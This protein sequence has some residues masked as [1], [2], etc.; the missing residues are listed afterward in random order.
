MTN[1]EK[2]K[3]YNIKLFPTY[4]MVA[5]DFIFFYAIEYVFLTSVKNFSSAQVVLLDSLIPLFC[6][7]VNIPC[8][9][10]VEK[11][12]K[13]VGMAVSNFA[14]M[15]CLILLILG[16]NIYY[17][18]FGFFFNAIGFCLKRL[19]DTNFLA[20][21]IEMKS[22]EGRKLFSTVIAISNRNYYVLD[23]VTS[24]L[25]GLT[26]M[27]NG[28]LP[29]I[30]SLAFATMAFVISLMFKNVET[31][32]EKEEEE[33][34]KVGKAFKREFKNVIDSFKT[35]LKS[36]R[37]RSFL[38]F[39]LAFNGILYGSYMLRST[40]LSE[41]YEI[42]D[43]SLAFL[44]AGMT[45]VSGLTAIVQEKLKDK[46]RNKNLAFISLVFIGTYILTS[47]VAGSTMPF[48]FKL[49][50]TIFFFML[51]Y[52]INSANEIAASSYSKNFTTSKIRVKISAAYAI[53]KN[54]SEFITTFA[55]GL[56]LEGIAIEKLFMYI[57]LV[58]AVIL[59]LVLLYM[60]KHFG[61]KPEEYDKSEI[62]D[63][64]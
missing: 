58:F 42:D 48:Y 24:F 52:I 51:Q 44:T 45:L 33:K 11:I 39:V 54:L 5:A 50:I 49:C 12:G 47:V 17:V 25:T 27:I 40:M 22:K 41:Y 56:L 8:T 60:R 20:E 29:M 1:I 38:L 2:K 19:V 7:L 63:A 26:F 32:E 28:Y 46:L 37:I 10:F 23:G 36:K 18:A 13:K 53:V 6:I 43:S 9:V 57:G 14:M 35:L 61:L 34:L 55:F 4:S 31:K 59:I 16:T 30:I 64:K 15:L 62:F 3:D 21:N